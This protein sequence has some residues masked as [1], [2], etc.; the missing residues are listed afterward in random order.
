MNNKKEILVIIATAIVVCIIIYLISPKSKTTIVEVNEEQRGKENI[1]AILNT[2]KRKTLVET[3]KIEPKVTQQIITVTEEEKIAN[4]IKIIKADGEKKLGKKV[5]SETFEG[6]MLNNDPKKTIEGGDESS[7]IIQMIRKQQEF[8]RTHGYVEQHKG[9]FETR[10]KSIIQPYSNAEAQPNAG[11]QLSKLPITLAN[12]YVGFTMIDKPPFFT[13]LNYKSY[14][15]SRAFNY[16][17]MKIALQEIS[18][19]SGGSHFIEAAVNEHIGENPAVSRTFKSE[20]SKDSRIYNL[21]TWNNE[22]YNYVLSSISD[23][24]N[25]EQKKILKELAEEITVMNDNMNE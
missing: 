9:D 23:K 8:E 18:N 14:V 16:K 10:Y 22:N 3:S 15:I 4:L 11:F 1:A 13:N 7:E 12:G 2:N 17:D 6:A 24:S 25:S 21:L 20:S 5:Y 19:K